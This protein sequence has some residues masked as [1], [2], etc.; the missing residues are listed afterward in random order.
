MTFVLTLQP[1]VKGYGSKITAEKA[2]LVYQLGF[3]DAGNIVVTECIGPPVQ[4]PYYSHAPR[5]TTFV[6]LDSDITDAESTW[7]YEEGDARYCYGIDVADFCGTGYQQVLVEDNELMDRIKEAQEAFRN[8]HLGPV[9]V[10]LFDPYDEDTADG[11]P[12]ALFDVRVKD[13]QMWVTNGGEEI[14]RPYGAHWFQWHP[15]TPYSDGYFDEL[16]VANWMEAGKPKTIWV[17]PS[18]FKSIAAALRGEKVEEEA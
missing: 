14:D 7:A 9:V 4:Y 13:G 17:T 1:F 15:R 10:T 2:G 16:N 12:I 18:A 8:E 5:P 11:N 3:D 6:I